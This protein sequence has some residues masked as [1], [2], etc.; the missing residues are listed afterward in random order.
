M[1]EQESEGISPFFRKTPY[2]QYTRRRFPPT[3]QPKSFN[4]RS[5]YLNHLAKK[6]VQQARKTLDLR[7]R[8]ITIRASKEGLDLRWKIVAN[9]I[10]KLRQQ[11]K[12][13]DAKQR[14]HPYAMPSHSFRPIG[15]GMVQLVFFLNK[16]LFN[17]LIDSH[18]RTRSWICSSA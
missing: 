4:N 13:M 5:N 3:N 16:P 7:Q 12:S 6:R 11:A 18:K 8:L 17:Y 14:F 1:Q 2:A 10:F 15:C 9:M